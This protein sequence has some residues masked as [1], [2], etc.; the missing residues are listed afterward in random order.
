MIIIIVYSFLRCQKEKRQE[1]P[2]R[3]RIWRARSGLR[4]RFDIYAFEKN[5]VEHKEYHGTSPNGSDN[6]KTRTAH[7]IQPNWMG[8]NSFRYM[9]SPIHPTISVQSY[10]QDLGPQG[11]STLNISLY[12]RA[13]E[14]RITQN[15]WWIFGDLDRR[16]H[17]PRRINRT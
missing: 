2:C 1:I 10:S 3:V 6:S 13:G 8:W 15:F 16:L 11:I 12:F 5:P 7:S 4:I 17:L 14:V 9:H